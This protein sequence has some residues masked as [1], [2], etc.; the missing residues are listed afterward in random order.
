MFPPVSSYMVCSA[1]TCTRCVALGS[2]VRKPD[3]K[4]DGIGVGIE[5]D[6]VKGIEDGEMLRYFDGC[7]E[8]RVLE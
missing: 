7:V 5:L 3:G 4:A 2:N 8:G 1:T 6:S